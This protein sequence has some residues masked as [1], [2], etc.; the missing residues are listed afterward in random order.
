MKKKKFIPGKQGDVMTKG[1]DYNAKITDPAFDPTTVDLTPADVT[2]YTGIYTAAKTDYT[3]L[4]LAKDEKKAKTNKF[5]GPGGSLDQLVAILRNH[6][7][8]IRVS[9]ASDDTCVKLGVDRRKA[10]PSPKIAPSDA[11]E[12][13]L[14][15]VKPGQLNLRARTSGV[16]GPRSRP[17]TSTGI[18]IAVVD[19]TAAVAAGEAN[20]AP[21][22]SVSRSPFTLDS[23]GWPAK[24][25]LYARWETARKE[26]SGWSL[27]LTVTVL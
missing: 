6:G 17:D 12:F 14:V 8:I 23:T 27:P 20:D 13:T 5:S 4:N 3:N 18:Q 21:I 1:A 9:P 10:S 2:E 22:K 19:G 11:P 15:S 24:V 16:A 7:N 25:R 26:V